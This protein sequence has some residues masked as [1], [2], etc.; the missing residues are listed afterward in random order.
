MIF[1]IENVLKPEELNWVN[2]QILN[3]EFV[4][5]KITGAVGYSVKNNL[6]LK[7]DYTLANELNKIVI[8]ALW[9]AQLFQSDN[10]E[11]VNSN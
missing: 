3:G 1:C 10:S 8:Q 6:Q 5:G 2:S 11:I 9:R 7:S 4:D